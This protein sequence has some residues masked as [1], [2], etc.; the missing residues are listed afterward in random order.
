MGRREGE[1]STMPTQR[2]TMDKSVSRMMSAGREYSAGEAGEMVV[3]LALVVVGV[4]W[5]RECS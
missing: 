2:R 1:P 4:W 3:L 5:A